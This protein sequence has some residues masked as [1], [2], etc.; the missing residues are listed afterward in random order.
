MVQLD[1]DAA[2]AA[3]ALQTHPFEVGYSQHNGAERAEW[4][5]GKLELENI[6]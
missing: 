2:T 3:A 4:S 6:G 1:F 5:T